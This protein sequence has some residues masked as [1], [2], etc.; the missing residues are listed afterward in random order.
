M[1][2]VRRKAL[3]EDAKFDDEMP[4]R[5][6]RVIQWAVEEEPRSLAAKSIGLAVNDVYERYAKDLLDQTT[7]KAQALG[8]SAG[9]QERECS[10]MLCIA[11]LET[12]Q[13]VQGEAG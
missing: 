9:E 1:K 4:V 13:R 6:R 12:R 11:A 10:V 2:A 5:V 3:L 8:V 7:A